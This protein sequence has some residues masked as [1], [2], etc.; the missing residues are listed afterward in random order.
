[1]RIIKETLL[2]YYFYKIRK[3]L[4]LIGFI[5]FFDVVFWFFI[6]DLRDLSEKKF[7]FFFV[8]WGVFFISFVAVY[9]IIKY[10]N[11]RKENENK[12]EEKTQF[13]PNEIQKKILEKENL[14]SKADYI[15]EKYQ[16]R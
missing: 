14:K 7:L 10:K 15:I 16:R 1:M 2:V 12:S 11:K 8:K 6:E 4:F 3:K 9:L 5:L 13:E